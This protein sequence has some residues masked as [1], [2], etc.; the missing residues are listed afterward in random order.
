MNRRCLTLLA[1][2]CLV[3]PA[4]G[5]GAS[6]GD[7]RGQR[8]AVTGNVTLDG[9]PLSQARILF[10]SNAGGGT[11]KATAL[12]ED[13]KFAMD[14]THGP[15]AGTARVEIHPELIELDQ[16]EAERQDNPR[17]RVDPRP[18]TIPSRYNSATELAAV[19]SHS[20]EN[21]FTFELSSR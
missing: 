13:G 18:L 10:I 4:V 6:S 9:N 12:V 7:S 21:Q 17:Q 16:L 15:L 3:L 14:A 5:C 19:V 20:E 11:V 1:L 8:V 2:L